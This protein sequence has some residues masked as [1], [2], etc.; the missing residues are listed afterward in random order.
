MNSVLCTMLPPKN[1]RK[2]KG[3]SK[4]KAI[5]SCMMT[6]PI[7]NISSDKKKKDK[8]SGELLKRSSPK[9]IS[10][11]KSLCKT[12]PPKLSLEGALLAL[13]YSSRGKRPNNSSP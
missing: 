2:N 10:K 4:L 3:R 5:M 1:K 7:K 13:S 9:K 8:W 11:N 6:S 12:L